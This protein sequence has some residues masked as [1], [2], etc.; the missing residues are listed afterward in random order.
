MINNKYDPRLK[1]YDELIN[2]F[3]YGE[4]IIN[5]LKRDLKPEE[6]SSITRQSWIITGPRG[7]GKSHLLTLLFH[8]IENCDEL[9]R[10]W[11]PLIFPEELFKVDSLYRLMIEVLDKA[12]KKINPSP[13][14][15]ELKKKFENL[16]KFKLKGP[17]ANKREEK[18]LIAGE[19][20]EILLL[21]KERI[22]KKFILLFENLQCL[23]RDQ[24]PEDD[25]KKLRSFLNENP[26][27]FIIIGTALAVFND[28]DNYGKP[29][30]HFFRLRSMDADGK[31]V[32]TGFLRKIAAFRGDP[33]IDEKIAS[34]RHYIHVYNILT[35]GNPRLILFLYEL[36]I[37][38]SE[39]NTQTILSKISELTPYFLDKT[40]DES[41]QRKLILDALSDG[42]PA[43]T[44]TEIGEYINE[45]QK[46]I[47]EQ[48]KRLAA[49]GWIREILINAKNVK[50][51][52]VFFVLRDYF[53]RIW[54]KVRTG[55]ID[56]SDTFCMAELAVMLFDK[57]EIHKRMNQ[58]EATSSPNQ[59]VY[60]MAYEL[61]VDDKFS[62][63]INMLIKSAQDS[64]NSEIEEI[65]KNI[66][67]ASNLKE[68]KQ[69]QKYAKQ[70]IDY[71]FEKGNACFYSGLAFNMI[72]EHKKAIE[73]YEKAVKIK[74]DDHTSWYNMGISYSKLNNQEKAIECFEK[75]VKI[76][77]DLY[78]SWNSM[79]VSYFMLNN[80]E[81]SIEC[82]EKAVEI[83]KDSHE[84]WYNI[85]NH[86]FHLNKYEDAYL[87]YMESVRYS[88]AL[89]LIYFNNFHKLQTIAKSIFKDSN[90]LKNLL[91]EKATIEVKM[92]AMSRLLL[93]GKFIAVTDTF[94]DVVKN[95][96]ILPQ[97]ESKKLE[98][99]I[100]AYIFQL[101]KEGKEDGE[102]TVM[103]K[104]WIQLN[105]KILKNDEMKLMRKFL[106]F[107]RLY[108]EFVGK[109]NVSVKVIEQVMV[110]LREKGVNIPDI[111]LNILK[112]VKTPDTREA[113]KW[114]ADPLF[115]E[116]VSML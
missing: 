59:M 45:E 75:A 4:E 20:L 76:K 6:K 19:F 22:N 112:A 69:I 44:A 28:I 43:Q 89:E 18:D 71:P 85:G 105:L 92:E 103:F 56:Q 60:Q 55:D 11:K 12:F 110:D 95:Q 17:L 87:A 100:Q 1:S 73:Y 93:L 106:E 91:D 94:E 80:Q 58:H 67:I 79:G 108:I 99:F 116:I 14:I 41:S 104:S 114:M 90:E 26:D 35:G 39:L 30:Y 52:E 2:T 88:P 101:L 63:N 47:S 107:F 62:A 97:F 53:Y 16:K 48:L 113:Q 109:E 31:G 65:Y 32:I 74:K 46:S 37:D 81:K 42:P 21:L 50:K 49:E 84:S 78:K 83:K 24:I 57:T 34:N 10:C 15:D 98:F 72:D 115:K 68:W 27:V 3:V 29:F 70:L 38:S 36:L 51:K 13:E 61:A 96:E 25:Q 9:N 33:G 23:F 111:I 64:E 102:L 54:Y 8:E 82:F 86:Y 7:A 66:V 40:R 5:E 77:K